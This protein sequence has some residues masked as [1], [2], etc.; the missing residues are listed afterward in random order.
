MKYKRHP[1]RKVSHLLSLPFILSVLIPLVIFDIFLEFYHQVCFR[2]YR[3]PRVKRSEYIK[4]DRHRLR[5]LN[6]REK[7]FCLYCSYANGFG[8]YFVRIAA[9]TERYWCAIKHK[10]Y[11][12]FHA[13]A[14][15][16]NFLPYG[17]EPAFRKK[18][19]KP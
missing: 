17:D 7:L 6:T 9:D 4:F 5:Y 11:K 19:G 12:G 13:P 10:Q 14:H 15:H 16:K 2:L 3:I 18:Y 8:Q 1:E